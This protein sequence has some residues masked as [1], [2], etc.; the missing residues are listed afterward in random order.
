MNEHNF[1]E[2]VAAATSYED[3]FVPALFKQWAPLVLNSANV[4]S[5]HRVLDVACGTGVLAREAASRVGP[6]G[7]TAGLDIAAGM[8]EVARRIAPAIDWKQGPADSL[9]F[10]D[11][12]FDAVVSQFGLMFFPDREKSMRE[13]L[14]VLVPEGR[15]SVA[16][17]DSLSNL[18]AYAD[19]VALL[20][21]SAGKKA[22]DALR[23]PFVLGQ[24]DV[25]VQLAEKS[26]VN[27]AKVA[28]HSG[29][30]K[31]PSVRSLVEADLRGW[32]PMM[33]IILDEEKIQQIL[34][35]A[36]QAL[37]AYVDEH[38]QVVFPVSAHIIIGS[39][40]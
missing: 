18:P 40:S 15:L 37:S 10:P 32:L 30:A 16:V 26:G 7:Y 39:K 31:F 35:D 17:F 3:L 21:R 23:A 25:L 19:E 13:M 22:A 8:L 27:A 38:G 29:T 36:E 34:A 33:G 14:R 20:E 1:Q 4:Q 11:Q 12:S 28:T 2:Q 24:K 6:S 9:P 5:G